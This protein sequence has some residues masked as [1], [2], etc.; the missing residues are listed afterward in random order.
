MRH[1]NVN[2]D[3]RIVSSVVL[4]GE[5]SSLR[6]F[7][8]Q[9]DLCTHESAYVCIHDSRVRATPDSINATLIGV[10]FVP[11]CSVISFRRGIARRTFSRRRLSDEP[12]YIPGSPIDLVIDH[13]WRY[14]KSYTTPIM[15]SSCYRDTH[16]FAIDNYL[17]M[18][19]FVQKMNIR[20]IYFRRKLRKLFLP[21][22]SV[23][24]VL[25]Y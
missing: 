21:Y 7:I 1:L 10:P 5:R 9:A 18:E 11:V 4:A 23:M 14:R 13:D 22:V 19:I 6:K 2:H 20:L 3:N 12:A 17:Q 25:H 15:L 16:F 24:N 8:M